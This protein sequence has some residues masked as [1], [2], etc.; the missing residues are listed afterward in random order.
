MPLT[1]FEKRQRLEPKTDD[2]KANAKKRAEMKAAARKE[3][4]GKTAVYRTAGEVFYRNGVTHPP[5]SEVRLP[6]EE[7]PSITWEPVLSD[8][9]MKPAASPASEPKTDDKKAPRASD[10]TVG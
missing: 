2:Q 1:P 7:D 4:D 3:S 8:G 5:Y 9:V 10:K 6:I